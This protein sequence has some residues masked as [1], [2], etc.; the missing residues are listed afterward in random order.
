MYYVLN[1]TIFLR[2]ENVT[3]LIFEYFVARIWLSMQKIM[4]LSSLVQGVLII[5]VI[6]NVCNNNSK[7][8]IM[9]IKKEI[10]F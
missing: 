6:I 4:I 9:D 10:A 3:G 5:C 7:V 1:L 2:Y 8:I